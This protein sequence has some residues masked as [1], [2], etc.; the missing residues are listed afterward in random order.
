MRRHAQVSGVDRSFSGACGGDA[1]GVLSL[2]GDVPEAVMKELMS[3]DA[4]TQAKI[5]NLP[6]AGDLPS[7]MS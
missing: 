6:A 5:I 2:D 1:I 7:W 3:L 4:I